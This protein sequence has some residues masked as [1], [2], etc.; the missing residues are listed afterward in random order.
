MRDMSK[1]T[2][3]L[4][5]LWAFAGA[6]SA[7]DWPQWRYDSGHTAVSPEQLP[8]TLAPRWRI[9]LPRLSPAWVDAV[10]QDRM[11]FDRAYRPV[12]QERSSRD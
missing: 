4:L 7:S 1:N 11:P 10:N 5:I 3:L 9:D 2:L 8:T 12:A 6:S